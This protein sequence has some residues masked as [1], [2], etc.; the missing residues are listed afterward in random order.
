MRLP[1]RK[2]CRGRC[3]CGGRNP[4]GDDCAEQDHP[5]PRF[6]ETSLHE[7]PPFLESP[8]TCRRCAR[9]ERRPEPV[10]LRG[11][12]DTSAA[13]ISAR[14]E[15]ATASRPVFALDAPDDVFEWDARSEERR[16]G[17]ECR[18]RWCAYQYTEKT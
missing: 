2:G 1:G 3:R 12:H 4:A 18:P 13:D 11:R 5:R 10:R 8:W 15:I 7:M 6:F 16:V 14:A 17:K 9:R